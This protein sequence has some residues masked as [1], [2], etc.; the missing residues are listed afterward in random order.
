MRDL[1]RCTRVSKGE[2]QRE[3]DKEEEEGEARIVLL[4]HGELVMTLI[5]DDDFEREKPE[6]KLTI[7]K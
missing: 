2:H 1:K 5:G 7:A 6:R 3:M 4:G